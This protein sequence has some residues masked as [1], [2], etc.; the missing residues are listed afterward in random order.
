MHEHIPSRVALERDFRMGGHRFGDERS[1]HPV[2][3]IGG[4]HCEWSF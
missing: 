3:G 4:L 1:C 2:V